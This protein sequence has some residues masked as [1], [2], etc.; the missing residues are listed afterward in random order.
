MK[1]K[2]KNETAKNLPIYAKPFPLKLGFT[3]ICE[4]VS[5]NHLLLQE[6]VDIIPHN[7][8]ANALATIRS[9]NS[10][11]TD[12]STSVCS[13][14][15]PSIANEDANVRNTSLA[16]SILTPEEQITL[17]RLST[18]N[19]L[20]LAGSIV[21]G[22]RSSGDLLVQSL[23]KRELSETGAVEAAA[24]RSVAATAT[25]DVRETLLLLCSVDDGCTGTGATAATAGAAAITVFGHVAAAAGLDVVI[26]HIAA[27]GGLV[28]EL[29]AVDVVAGGLAGDG[30]VGAALIGLDD[31]V[32]S[33]GARPTVE[34]IGVDGV[35][36]GQRQ[37]NGCGKSE[38]REVH[39]EE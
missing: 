20:A 22:L 13:I 4:Y 8:R 3:R 21:L 28:P 7:V 31:T 29:V 33:T 35:S 2:N 1:Y 30:E 14:D 32:I 10:L 9:P 37:S 17:L 36:A 19:P 12:R 15:H 24:G 25:P 39:N 11:L 26:G 18:R 16:V 6:I 5:A 38:E 34:I 23:A 27:V